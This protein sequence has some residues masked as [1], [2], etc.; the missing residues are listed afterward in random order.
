MTAGSRYKL[1]VLDLDGTTVASRGDALPSARVIDAVKSAQKYVDVCLATG[2]T[3]YFAKD[4]IKEL[5]LTGPGVFSGGAEIIQME[6]GQIISK[7]HLSV[8]KMHEILTLLLPFG[9][10]VLSDVNNFETNIINHEALNNE[11][12]KII[13]LDCTITEAQHILEELSGLSGITAHMS[14][15]WVDDSL[16]PIEITHARAD[17]R[18]G[19]NRLINMLGYNKQEI[20]AIGDNFNDVP[21]LEAAGLKILMGNAPEQLKPLANYVAPPLAEDGLAV[22]IEKYILS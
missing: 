10:T 17:K 8:P 9:H 2:R 6:T 11:A 20:I 19:V 18:H 5:G 3:Y 15:S 14:S 13:V 16:K 21:L 1:L 4:I 12:A 7:Q 22:A